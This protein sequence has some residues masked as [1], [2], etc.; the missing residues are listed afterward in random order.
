LRAY[1]FDSG[2]SF[3]RDGPGKNGNG[4][5]A[6]CGIN[7]GKTGFFGESDY[8]FSVSVCPQCLRDPTVN[9]RLS[10]FNIKENWREWSR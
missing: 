5:C 9:L 7:K 1:G 2:T 6:F 4:V 10:N 3:K 8:G